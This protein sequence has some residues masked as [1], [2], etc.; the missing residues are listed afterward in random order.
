[1]AD[2]CPPGISFSP[3]ALVA[4][5]N[6]SRVQ[7]SGWTADCSCAWI[8]VLN[9]RLELEWGERG[10]EGGR[11]EVGKQVG[12]VELEYWMIYHTVGKLPLT[13]IHFNIII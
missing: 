13:V 9:R 5:A 12:V 10:H 3:H 2:G 11:D 1:M 6:N 7:G 4:L 8:S